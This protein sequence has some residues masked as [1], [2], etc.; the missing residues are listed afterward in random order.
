MAE[1]KGWTRE[2][3]W[4]QGSVLPQAAAAH[5]GLENERDA[6]ATCAVV[7]SHDC[8]LANDDLN[9]EPDVEVIVGRTV[10]AVNGNFAWAKV[11]RTLHATAKRGDKPLNIELLATKKVTLPKAGLAAFEPDST[12]RLDSVEVLRSWL[13][14]RYKRAAFADTFVNRMGDSKATERLGK[15]VE[16]YGATLSFVYFTVDEGN[17][18]ERAA[19]DPYDLSVVL[20]YPPGK[21][22]DAAGDIADKAAGEVEKALRDSFAKD[23]P[24]N[25]KKCF[26]MSED[27]LP[28]S[29]ARE[30][31]Q[32]RLEHMTFRA[33][34]PQPSPPAV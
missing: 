28:V 6:V 15:I 13:S 7:I 22:P 26:S 16:R 1:A 31:Q 4:R 24:I 30:L 14:S 8:D 21:D 33:K 27:D 29:R 25:L 2:T 5:F 12:V 32:W 17:L 23:K 20:V 9:A 11:P 18:V 19:G 34:Q 3:T 10:D